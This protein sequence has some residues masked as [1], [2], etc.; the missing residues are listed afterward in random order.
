METDVY[1]EDGKVQRLCLMLVGKA[2]LW[3]ESL[4][5]TAVDG[6]GLQAQ[7]RWQYSRICNAREQP[8]Y[9]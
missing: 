4:R 7:F 2:R 3:Y 6:K 8:F 1:P 5:P 9:A